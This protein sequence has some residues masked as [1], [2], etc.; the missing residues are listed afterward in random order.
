MNLTHRNRMQSLIAIVLFCFLV[1]CTKKDQTSPDL[2]ISGQKEG[3]TA[4]VTG[5]QFTLVPDAY[6]RLI[7][8]NT[9]GTYKAGDVLNLKGN[10]KA[11]QIT[12][13]SGSAAAP[14]LIQNPAGAVTTVG[15][16]SWNGGSYAGGLVFNNCHYIKLGSA[17]SK[18]S[19]VINGSTQANR[20]AYF[21][22]Q[23]RAHTD[24]FEIQYLTLNNGGTG[25]VAKTDPVKGDASTV[26]PNSTMENL[27][28]HDITLS[29]TINEGMYIGHTATYWDLTANAPYYGAASAF[30]TGHN[31]VQPIKWH[32]VKIYKNIVQNIGND[33]IQTAAIDLL[34]V[35]NNTVT[36]WATR[37]DAGNNGGIL[38][39]GRTTN[40]NTHDN[41]VHDG[42]GDLCQF[43]GSGLNG[44]THVIHNNLFRNGQADGI[45]M[46]GYDNAVVKITNNTV[47]NTKANSIRINGYTG[48]PGKQLANANLLIMPNSGGVVY[49]K[50]YIYTENGGAYTEGTGI[51]V[52]KK[53][54]TAAKAGGVTSASFFQPITSAIAVLIGAAGYR[55]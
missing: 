44:A 55:N 9:K 25:I 45:S 43:Y 8:D 49:D 4:A 35:Y 20:S 27:S 13:L 34:E 54:A 52:N 10:F 47:Y 28:I 50:N 29:G 11:I 32:N 1:S 14:I 40:T 48:M 41:Y 21:N 33:A 2:T 26:Y 16:P 24:N 12:N 3:V 39:G 22:I 23:L 30:T 31:Y 5:R 6:G 37:H 53:F 38:I 19:F 17:T 15:D 46:R 51:N 36:N 7:I 42:W 18:S